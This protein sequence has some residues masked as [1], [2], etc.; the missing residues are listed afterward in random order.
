MFLIPLVIC[1]VLFY[2][3]AR[4]WLPAGPVTVPPSET[5]ASGN[6]KVWAVKH[7]GLY[8]CPDSKL[9]ETV[10]PGIMMAQEKALEAG[11]R[12]AGGN[13]CR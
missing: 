10:K 7:T 13:P 3:F 9:Y 4:R 1:W 2:P 12:P 6:V 11:Y 5:S 8:Y